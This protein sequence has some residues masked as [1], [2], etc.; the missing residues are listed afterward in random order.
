MDGAVKLGGKLVAFRM[1]MLSLHRVASC[2][3]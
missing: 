3:A 2:P 1:T